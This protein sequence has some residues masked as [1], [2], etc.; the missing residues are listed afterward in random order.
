[1]SI[2]FIFWICCC[3]DSLKSYYF[4][5]QKKQTNVDKSV[6]ICFIENCYCCFSAQFE[7][8]L[9]HN[10]THMLKKIFHTCKSCL[11]VY[12]KIKYPSH[13]DSLHKIKM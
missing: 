5:A 3:V 9:G 10:G 12:I 6:S 1:M 2:L 13:C 11:N 8:R 7:I 4:T